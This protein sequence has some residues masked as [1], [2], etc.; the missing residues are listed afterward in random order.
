MLHGCVGPGRPPSRLF[1]APLLCNWPHRLTLIDMRTLLCSKEDVAQVGYMDNGN[2]QYIMMM[3]MIRGIIWASF[4][5]I[6]SHLCLV[7]PM[8][9]KRRDGRER[10]KCSWGHEPDLK[11]IH[12]C[13]EYVV[14]TTFMTC[15][16]YRWIITL[17]VSTSYWQS[18]IAYS[19]IFT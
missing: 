13:C 15:H 11:A 16:P 10:M 17:Y 8:E 18:H 1:W 12:V 7:D 19:F 6:V 2:V 5:K 4:N 3:M 14:S 9:S